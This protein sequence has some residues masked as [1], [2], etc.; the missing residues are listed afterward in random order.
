M[1]C[2]YTVVHSP[3]TFLNI[4]FD[5]L[6]FGIEGQQPKHK[7]GLKP[8]EGSANSTDNSTITRT[9]GPVTMV[10]PPTPPLLT[11]TVS[12]LF[13]GSQIPLNT[14]TSASVADRF[15]ELMLNASG[16]QKSLIGGNNIYVF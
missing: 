11:T 12:V 4:Y 5:P 10:T 14:T 8:P 13:Q 15:R 6:H 9:V 1:L 16:L 3:Q 7:L 2:N